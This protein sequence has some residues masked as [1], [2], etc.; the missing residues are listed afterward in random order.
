MLIEKTS[1]VNI[2]SGPVK[3]YGKPREKATIPCSRC[4]ILRQSAY[5]KESLCFHC[6]ETLQKIQAWLSGDLAV[7]Y[8][9]VAREPAIFVK[10]YIIER[11]G[12]KCKVCNLSLCRADG[13]SIIQLNHIDGNYLNNN[14]NN[15]ELLCPNHH[16]ITETWG[17]KNKQKSRRKMLKEFSK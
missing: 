5:L 2:T 17:S 15:L 14:P 3:G 10:K 13:M 8:Y 4:G 9:G 16:A 7:S 11:D 6:R 12:D 1:T